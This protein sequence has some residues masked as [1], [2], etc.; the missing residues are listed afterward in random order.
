MAFRVSFTEEADYDP[1]LIV[2][3]LQE[4]ETGD[5]VFGSLT[6]LYEEAIDVRKALEGLR[7]QDRR[8]SYVAE[9]YYFEDLSIRQ[10]ADRMEICERSAA[11]KLLIARFRL[12]ED[13]AT[14]KSRYKGRKRRRSR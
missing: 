8:L 10:V 6:P 11:R 9:L 1:D 7:R 14:Y 4:A 5:S 2:E 3:G 13:L 12:S